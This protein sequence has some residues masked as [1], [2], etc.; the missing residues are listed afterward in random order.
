MSNKYKDDRNYFKR[1]RDELEGGGLEALLYEL[2]HENI[3]DFDPWLLPQNIE[4]FEVKL[5]SASSIERYIYEALCYGTFDLGNATPTQPWKSH[6]LCESV[7]G[8]YKIW[9][10]NQS[11]K[12]ENSAQFGKLLRKLIPSIKEQEK[13]QEETVLITTNY[14]L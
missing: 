10:G 12:L 9:C 4:A 14:L 11:L 5:M 7:Y 13:P 2:E 8:D 6:I 1:I 3:S